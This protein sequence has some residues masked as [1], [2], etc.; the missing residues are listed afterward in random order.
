MIRAVLWDFGGVITTSPFE[1]FNRYERERDIPRDFIR[2]VNATSPDS[3]AWAQLES[4]AIDIATFDKLFA[5]ET[6]AAG[7]RIPGVDVLRL[8]SGD[9]RPEMV[10][11]LRA[12]KREYRVACITNNVRDAGEGPGMAADDSAAAQVREAMALFDFVI[13]S[14]VVGLRKPDPRI[15]ELA[16]ERLEVEP[17]ETVFIDDLG[18][19][20]KPA[21][22]MGMTTVKAVSAAQALEE[23]GDILDL[24]LT[25]QEGSA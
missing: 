5:Q 3:N 10:D 9:V 16:C 23:L 11:A 25:A 15:Y 24:Q 20:L 13:E 12:I 2:S 1:A 8:L 4:S 7:H 19:N 17:A 22:A 18:I 6:G 14:S 21:R